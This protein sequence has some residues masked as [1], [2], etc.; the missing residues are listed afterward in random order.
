MNQQVDKQYVVEKIEIFRM[1]HEDKCEDGKQITSEARVKSMNE[2]K[3]RYEQLGL[4]LSL[5]DYIIRILRWKTYR[6]DMIFWER[7][8]KKEEFIRKNSRSKERDDDR[9][10]SRNR[11][12]DFNYRS[13]S[14]S[15]DRSR[16]D[17][18]R[19]DRSNERD[20]DEYNN[21][22]NDNERKERVK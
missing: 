5:E 12:R 7:W 13:R 2:I 1:I 20:G 6:E 19:R 17:D 14:R 22:S 8:D 3:M 16:R 11:R 9:N 15:R 4:K 18:R 21:G 10:K